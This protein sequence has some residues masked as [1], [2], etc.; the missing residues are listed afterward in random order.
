MGEGYDRARKCEELGQI[1][2]FLDQLARAVERGEVPRASYDAL[3]PRYVTRRDEIVSALWGRTAG[4]IVG[5]PSELTA[6]A[7]G[8]EIAKD[9]EAELTLGWEFPAGAT[10]VESGVEPPAQRP[11]ESAGRG[12][13]VASGGE[14]GD[15]GYRSD[16]AG[17]F[18]REPR[19]R[20]HVAWTTVLLF[21][22]AFMVISAAAIFALTVWNSVGPTAKLAFLGVLTVAFY[23][24][25]YYARTK[26]S[27]RAGGTALTVVASAMLLF[28]CWIA[29]DGFNLQGPM[30]WAIALLF[31]S[32]VYWVTEV[33]L[34]DRFYGIAGAAAQVGWWWLMA[35]GLHLDSAVRFGGIAV[36]ALV[37]QLVAQRARDDETFASLANVLLWAAPI[38]ELAALVG[39]TGTA[40]VTGTATFELV[41]SA[42]TGCAAA[43]VV[44]WRTRVLP[45]NSRRWIA[46]VAQIPLFVALGMGGP[47]TWGGT[48]FLAA[49]TIAYALVALVVAGIPLAIPALLAE[50]VTLTSVLDLIHATPRQSSGALALLAFTWVLAYGI[51]RWRVDSGLP[52]WLKQAEETGSVLRWGG[53]ALMVAASLSALSAGNLSVFGGVTPVSADV[54]L[55][56]L[57]LAAWA[58]SALVRRDPEMAIGAVAWSFYSLVVLLLW[59]FPDWQP[60]AYNVALLALASVWL[61]SRGPMERYYRV[62][63]GALG[64][65]MRAL[66]ALLFAWGLMLQYDNLGHGGSWISLL[67]PVVVSLV[68]VADAYLTD[69]PAVAAAGA[70]VLVVAS[71]LNAAQLADR[72]LAGVFAIVAFLWVL[73]YGAIVWHRGRSQAPADSGPTEAATAMRWGGFGLLLVT[74]LS[75]PIIGHAVPLSGFA[76]SLSD[77]R[78]VAVILGA[79]VASTLVHRDPE[80]ASGT[81]AWSFYSLAAV[82][83][84][85]AAGWQS[86]VYASALVALAAVWLFTG[87]L[88]QRYFRVD[89]RVLGWFMRSLIALLLIG[90]LAAQSYFFGHVSAWPTVLL[91]ALASLVFL[92]DAVISDEPVSAA[93]GAASLV[94]AAVL[95]GRLTWGVHGEALVL[96]AAV[97]LIVAL[98]GLAL[99][100]AWPRCTP[101]LAVSAA[102]AGT[103][104]CWLGGGDWWVAAALALSAAS[105]A[106]AAAAG[107][108]ELVFPAAL[109]LLV[110]LATALSTAGYPGWVTVAVMGGAGLALGVSAFLPSTRKG[111]SH[112]RVGGLLSFAGVLPLLWLV[113]LGQMGPVLGTGGWMAIGEQ[114]IVASLLALGA[115]GVAQ[116][117]AWRIEPLFYMGF[118][119]VLLGGWAEFRALDW[120]TI[121]LFSTSLALYLAGMGYLYSVWDTPR[122]RIPIAI[123]AGVV[124]VGL[125]VPLVLALS[126]SFGKPMVVHTAW[127]IGLSLVAIAAGIAVRS[128]W[129]LF[130]GSG[131]LVL[132]SAWRSMSYLAQMWWLVLGLIGIALL[133]IALTWERQRQLIGETRERLQR[134]FED[135]R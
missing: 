48:A 18:I 6:P 8:L 114:G 112:E 31:T 85:T 68:F 56:S 4:P 52:E 133:V 73:A 51:I 105:F 21:V 33:S 79:W 54:V 57:M 117:V 43:G 86:G 20:V 75:A 134:S 97:G 5:L 94:A 110:S 104:S 41:A 135:W 39:L 58:A 92:G 12:S 40:F 128:R 22:G 96:S 100:N 25:G 93:A 26:L 29:I 44:A 62:G 122:R 101:W 30:P 87:A 74:S 50:V 32:I 36:I 2:F 17:R 53:L 72:R 65:V 95:L 59:A 123:D 10:P 120:T 108:E 111:S 70:T 19:E 46:G 89:A 121:E 61:F 82:M 35:D 49:L 28:D 3:A 125:G 34:G 63:S 98:M 81:V 118:F 9:T 115:Y 38:V 11:R 83:A 127:T 131:A 78:L 37:W 64:W 23:T 84:V 109:T 14:T 126:N 88:A 107:W 90:G 130:A 91:A 69:E 99:K 15:S 132:V 129:Y 66:I 42:A 113:W 80:P 119:A 102:V 60:G 76:I 103:A 7:S 16:Q 77:L 13:D 106:V 27:L 1:D 24:C 67:L 47:P 45:Q 71:L 124:A 116:A 55:A